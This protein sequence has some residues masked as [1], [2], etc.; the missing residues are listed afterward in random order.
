MKIISYLYKEVNSLLPAATHGDL[1][2]VPTIHSDPGSARK[3][4]DIIKITPISTDWPAFPSAFILGSG[5]ILTLLSSNIS[6][7]KDN[8]LKIFK[9]EILGGDAKKH[10][11]QSLRQSKPLKKILSVVKDNW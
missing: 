5:S 3:F 2:Q 8:P 10:M 7:S 11:K 1:K 4:D 9:K 6:Y